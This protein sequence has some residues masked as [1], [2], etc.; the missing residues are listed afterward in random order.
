[1]GF[2]VAVVVVEYERTAGG[3][4]MRKWRVTL[5]TGMV[6]FCMMTVAWATPLNMSDMANAL[7]EWPVSVSD[8]GGRFILS[9]CP[10]DV[11]REGILYQDKVKGDV[12][13]FFHHVNLMSAKKRIVV[14]LNNAGKLPAKVNVLRYGISGP[15][16]DYL[17]AGRAIQGE[18]LK[19]SKTHQLVLL[20][21]K[22][23]F[24]PQGKSGPALPFQMI[25]T[26]MIDFQVD[27]EVMLTVAAIPEIGDPAT[28]TLLY[29][30]LPPAPGKP[31][32]R[33]SFSHGDRALVGKR[34]YDPGKD[35]PVAITLGDGEIDTFLEGKDVTTGQTVHNRGN[36]GVVYRIMIPTTGKGKIRCYLNPRGGVYTGWA[37]VKTKTEHKVIG[38]PSKAPAFGMDTLA[39]FEL[40]AEFSAGEMLWVTLSPPGASNLPVRLMIVPAQ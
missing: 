12:R 29:D 31:H 38:T 3:V 16:P 10:E 30:V 18:Y 4:T 14:M 7:P 13:L 36:Y 8:S 34:V 5:L 1:M 9:D 37:A 19:E 35:G 17:R 26:G 20:P 15:D 21:G 2:A 39:D 28:W 25:F 33:G 27:Q 22:T 23:T 11:Q 6:S 40:I 32:L 24:L